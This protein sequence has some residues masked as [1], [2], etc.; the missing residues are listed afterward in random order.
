M[1]STTERGYGTAHQKTRAR[2]AR[3]LRQLGVMQ[4][5]TLI[6]HGD[7]WDLGHTDDRTGY[8][9]PQCIPCNRGAGGRNGAR[10]TNEKT[11]TITRTWG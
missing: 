6:H 7:R 5:P 1:K 3:R 9:G 8:L 11:K 10:K 2:W 4:C